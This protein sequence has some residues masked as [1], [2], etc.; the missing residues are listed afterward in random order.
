[1]NRLAWIGL[2]ALLFPC[3]ASAWLLRWTQGRPTPCVTCSPED[4]VATKYRPIIDRTPGA[5]FPAAEATP[6]VAPDTYQRAVDYDRQR[7]IHLQSG[8][9]GGWSGW[10]NTYKTPTPLKPSPPKLL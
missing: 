5:T 6:E 1:M 7:E 9:G 4:G 3:S 8:N 10:S 2:L